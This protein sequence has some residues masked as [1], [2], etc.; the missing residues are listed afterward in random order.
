MAIYT[1]RVY[2][3]SEARMVRWNT[4]PDPDPGLVSY[5][6]TPGNASD[7]V[8]ESVTNAGGVTDH[9]V[10]GGLTD[11]D[12]TQYALL[13]GRIGGQSLIGGTGAGDTLTLRATSDGLAGDHNIAVNDNLDLQTFNILGVGNYTGA[14]GTLTG[15]WTFGDG[16]VVSRTTAGSAIAATAAQGDEIAVITLISTTSVGNTN[17][18]ASA[19]H[20]GN[21][22]PNSN[23]DAVAGTIYV[24]ADTG[25]PANSTIYVKT[26]ASGS[27]TGWTDLTSANGPAAGANTEVQFNN[28]GVF[29]ASSSFTWDGSTVE[30]TGSVQ[31]STQLR[32][33]NTDP[34][35]AF[36]GVTGSGDLSPFMFLTTS[37][38]AALNGATTRI[39]VGDRDPNGIVSSVTGALYYR[40]DTGTPTNS[41]IYINHGG[42]VWQDVLGAVASV[43]S[44]TAEAGSVSLISAAPTTGAVILS[45]LNQEIDTVNNNTFYGNNAGNVG[46]HSG[47]DNTGFGRGALAGLTTGS[48]NVALGN[49]TAAALTTGSTNIAIGDGAFATATILSDNNVIIGTAAGAAI[50]STGASENV[51]IGYQAGNEWKENLSVVSSVLIGANS[52]QF[53][54]G[55]DGSA[56]TNNVAIGREALRGASTGRTTVS[57]NTAIGYSALRLID[58]N[59]AG[60]TAIGVGAGANV[61]TGTDNIFI[62]VNAGST[63]TTGSNNAIIGNSSDVPT[64]GTSNF[65]NIR[66]TI[67]GDTLNKRL[68]IGESAGAVTGDVVLRLEASLQGYSFMLPLLTDTNEGN[69]TEEDGMLHYNSTQGTLKAR[70]NGVWVTVPSDLQTAYNLGGSFNIDITGGND[71]VIDTVPSQS[72]L[73]GSA[74]GLFSLLRRDGVSGR[75]VTLAAPLEIDDS[76]NEGTSILIIAAGGSHSTS[77]A[78]IG[79]DAGMVTVGTFGSGGDGANSDGSTNATTAGDGGGVELTCSDGGDGGNAS[80]SF[81]ASAGAAGGN[82]TVALARG[83]IGGGGTTSVP[84]ADGGNASDVTITGDIGGAGGNSINSGQAAGAGGAGSGLTWIGGAGGAGGTDSGGDGAAGGG[85]APWLFVGAAGGA[86]TGTIG[87]GGNGTSF[88]VIC[89]PGGAADDGGDGGLGGSIALTPGSGG[90]NGGGGGSAGADGTI[91]LNGVT[92]IDGNVNI[93][94]N[95]SFLATSSTPVISQADQ[96]VNGFPGVNLTVQA[97]NS[98]GTTTTGGDLVLKPG[99]GTSIDGIIALQGNT[100]MTGNLSFLSTVGVPVISQADETANSVNGEI[101]TIQAQNST[102]TTTTGGNLE[103]KPGTGTA[104]NGVILVTGNTDI[105]GDVTITG[106]LGLTDDVT[107]TTATDTPTISQADETGT[108]GDAMTIQAQNATGGSSTGGDLDLLAGTGTTADGSVNIGS[109]STRIETDGTGIGFFGVTPV[110]RP[111]VSVDTSAAIRAALV[112]LGLITDLV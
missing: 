108:T 24:R 20:V 40:A 36:S 32:V 109:G 52:G 100:N 27:S 92:N 75:G 16:A 39:H 8:V 35:V 29:G 50:N 80:G 51:F 99:T 6:F 11:D 46:T 97:Q 12:H 89:G 23:V 106:T 18:G 48:G 1:N 72:S 26:T 95:I 71:L 112:S 60:N 88:L 78:N 55:T 30:V 37:N 85:A 110:A 31:A 98:T 14:T 19:I 25:T 7:Y 76:G 83:G 22:D 67:F 49:G 93:D 91:D 47:N 84:G 41:T 69:L 65:L 61:S 73:G 53:L 54:G 68:R 63:L 104:T 42:D 34:G 59:G 4:D 43:S 96:T 74:F 94:G 15:L 38:G 107:F 57:N 70:L 9:G 33:L 2:D 77:V 103:L 87:N 28:A 101:L 10:L 102:G 21:R 62:G 58:I 44:V 56:S 79:S 105:T 90:G 111:D 64:A 82:I 66:D 81:T 17:P 13:A 45:V 86:G 3:S 5:P